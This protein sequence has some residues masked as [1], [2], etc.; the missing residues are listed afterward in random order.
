MSWAALTSSA[1]LGLDF[2]RVGIGVGV[3]E[4]GRYR[5]VFAADLAQHVGVLVLRSDGLD[6]TGC[7]GTG[8]RGVRR[9]RHQEQTAEQATDSEFREGA[10]RCSR[11]LKL[12]GYARSRREADKRLSLITNETE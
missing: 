6:H 5:D 7:A 4:D 3:V 11:S 12:L 9:A 8:R 2:K 1:T 10:A